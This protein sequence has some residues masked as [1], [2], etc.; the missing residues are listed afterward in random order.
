MNFY[1]LF[2]ELSRRC[3]IKCEHCLRGEP[4]MKSMSSEI[5]I[6]CAKA[7]R[8]SYVS[9]VGIGG[10]EPS[11]I[12]HRI[13]LLFDILKQEGVDHDGWYIVTN[14]HQLSKSFIDLIADLNKRYPYNDGGGLTY[15]NSPLHALPDI[16]GLAEIQHQRGVEV[17][18]RYHDDPVTVKGMGTFLEEGRGKELF[19]KYEVKVT[20]RWLEP[21]S[22]REKDKP[23]E[24]SCVERTMYVNYRG[25]V[26]PSCD[27][28]YET[29]DKSKLLN[30]GKLWD[31]TEERLRDF[32]NW[33]R[34]HGIRNV[35]EI[36]TMEFGTVF[37]AL[38][39]DKY[40][41]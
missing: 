37:R 18:K 15:S 10:G 9:T 11:I 6:K 33:L 5:M 21:D 12:P 20:K 41:R 3:N 17:Y 35:E 36:L 14:A 1:N 34:Q 16:K 7:L 22:F 30:L 23:E 4:E 13:R 29:Q 19:D 38:P 28:S 2:F 25:D 32:D 40:R 39:Q 8:D 27:L 24:P 26:F 31:L